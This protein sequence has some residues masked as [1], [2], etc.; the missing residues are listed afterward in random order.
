ML[1]SLA[2]DY[3]Y[4]LDVYVERAFVVDVE[5]INFLTRNLNFLT[6]M[7][8]FLCFA[9]WYDFFISTTQSCQQI[10]NKQRLKKSRKFF[11]KKAENTLQFMAELKLE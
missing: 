8:Y 3:L 5:S 1:F 9:S 7:N 6:K 4:L 2:I 11:M 10:F